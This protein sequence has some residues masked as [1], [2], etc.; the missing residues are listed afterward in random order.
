MDD[1]IPIGEF[2]ER[3]GIS[4]KRLRSYGA[5]GLLV[6]AAVDSA[7]GYR[8]YSPVQLRDARVIDTLREAGMPLADIAALLRDPSCRQLDAWAQRVELDAAHKQ[9]A[10]D[11]ARRLLSIDATSS[12]SV[13]HARSRRE[14]IMRLRTATQTNIGQV[15]DN[16]EDAVVSND[17][18]AA[19]ADGMGGHPGGEIASSVAVALVQAAF[20]GRSLDELEAAVRAANRA[21]WDRADAS[22]EL[23]G[24][25][26]T[27]CA[28][29]LTGEG[30]LVVVNVGDSRACVLHE[31]SLTQLTNDHTV[32]A[33][34]VRRGELSEQEAVEHPQRAVL[35]RALGIGPD[36]EV[37]SAAHPVVEGDRVVVCTDGL[38]SEVPSDEIAALMTSTA[39]LQATAD[40]LV[41]RALARGGRD[42][43]SVVVADVTA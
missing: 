33:E 39:D 9:Q 24:M 7:S 18:L 22:A 40:A 16:N 42:N 6:P 25:G 38:Y 23:D 43:V 17:H 31:D 29:G 11:L 15:R 32:V 30:S 36:V 19:V 27:I 4:R 8:Y 26:A 1:L 12:T 5:D 41:E 10:V 20:T 35:T 37:D 14:S 3:S 28:V 13:Q 2:S 21:I 34:L